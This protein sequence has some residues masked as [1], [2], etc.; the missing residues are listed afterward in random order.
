MLI[1]LPQRTCLPLA[2]IIHV[3]SYAPGPNQSCRKEW[4]V[5][6]INHNL[7]FITLAAHTITRT[8]IPARRRHDL[9]HSV[10]FSDRPNL[11]HVLQRIALKVF[12]GRIK[13]RCIRNLQGAPARLV[14]LGIL[15]CLVQ[16]T[17]F[18][19]NRSGVSRLIMG[20]R[21]TTAPFPHSGVHLVV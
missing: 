6:N 18:R 9:A 1:P 13:D 21:P 16:E 3:Y 4:A 2:T 8:R 5:D 20:R 15:D 19:S 10:L 12:H 14:E 17:F 11:L 7:R